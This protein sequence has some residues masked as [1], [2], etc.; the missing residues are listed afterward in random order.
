MQ[1]AHKWHRELCFLLLHAYRGL[2]AYFLV[3]MRDVP[4]LPHT[5]LG[6]GPGAGHRKP[7]PT[8]PSWA[9]LER[10]ACFV[11][12]TVADM[13]QVCVVYVTLFWKEGVWDMHLQ[14]VEAGAPL[15]SPTGH[16]LNTCYVHQAL[17]TP[18]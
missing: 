11:S 9:G 16:L 14:E 15:G 10:A 12:V 13:L 1:H 7:R 5:E 17:L 18:C 6:K 8:C 3:I 4:E 2:R